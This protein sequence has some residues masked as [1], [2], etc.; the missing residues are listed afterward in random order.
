MSVCV[1]WRNWEGLQEN[2]WF[3]LL[4]TGAIR[5]EE[6]PHNCLSCLCTHPYTPV[7]SSC[8]NATQLSFHVVVGCTGDEREG[9]DIGVLSSFPLCSAHSLCFSSWLPQLGVHIYR[10]VWSNR[11]M[12][13]LATTPIVSSLLTEWV[14]YFG[15]SWLSFATCAVKQL[16]V[17][18]PIFL[19]TLF[20]I[21]HKNV[22][23]LT[24]H[25]LFL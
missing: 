14:E 7:S 9:G 17:A 16:K 18:A 5:S 12:C 20:L 4:K 25:C 24:G 13:G 22:I 3:L 15:C 6:P 11:A 10:L 1:C 8:G 23:L 21:S 19:L 2:S